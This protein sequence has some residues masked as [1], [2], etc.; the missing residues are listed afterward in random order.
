V[1]GQVQGGV[2]QCVMCK[3]YKGGQ[4]F[5][6]VWVWFKVGQEEVG[7]E[8]HLEGFG[9]CL[10]VYGAVWSL[11]VKDWAWL[12]RVCKVGTGERVALVGGVS[13]VTGLR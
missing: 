2:A 9:W 13:A 1:V 8:W 4:G 7:A 5:R 6:S 12:W 3:E 11:Y 10:S